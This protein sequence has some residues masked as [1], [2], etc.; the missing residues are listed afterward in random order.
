[1]DQAAHFRQEEQTARLTRFS[2]CASY[3]AARQEE[4]H[5]QYS[6]RFRSSRGR[7]CRGELGRE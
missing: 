3:R 2:V 1:M 4:R 7:V 6:G 5:G